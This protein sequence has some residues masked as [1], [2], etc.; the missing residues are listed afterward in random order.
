MDYAKLRIMEA[1]PHSRFRPQGG[2]ALLSRMRGATIVQIGG[3]EDDEW[4]EGG[5]LLIDYVQAGDSRVYRAVFAF[6]ELGLGSSGTV[7]SPPRHPFEND[8]PNLIGKLRQQ[9]IALLLLV[10]IPDFLK[11]I[12][13]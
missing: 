7:S 13:T 8:R 10:K 5:G 3:T 11:R 1:L 2:E 9:E 6:N 4:I 12:G